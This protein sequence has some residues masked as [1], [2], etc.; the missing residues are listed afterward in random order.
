MKI[1]NNQKKS[2][3]DTDKSITFNV[4]YIKNSD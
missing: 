3:I 1:W 2:K 4:I